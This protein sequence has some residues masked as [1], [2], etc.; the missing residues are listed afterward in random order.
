VFPN[1]L[2]SASSFL[3][4]QSSSLANYPGATSL[5]L[6]YVNSPNTVFDVANQN[7]NGLLVVGGLRSV[8][9][10][11]TELLNDARLMRKFEVG[12]QS[13]DATLGFYVANVSQ[14]FTRYSSSALL[15]VRDNARLLNLVAVNAAGNVIGTITDDGFYRYGYEWANA[16]G[17]STT[18]AFY[19][20][21]EWQV[22]DRLRIDLGVRREEVHLTANTELRQTVNLGTP[23][24]SAMI[25]GTGQFAHFDEKF[26]KAGW[27]IG[28][29]WQFTERSGLFS[30]Y[31][32]A[33]RLPNLST[34]V[35]SSPTAANPTVNKPIIQ[36]MDLGEVGYK[37]ANRWTN[38][39]ATAFWT[40]YDNVSFTNNVFNLNN[41]TSTTQ[42]LYAN[43]RT[44]GLELEGGF[45]PFDWFDVTLSGT[46]EHPEYD[47][48][49]YTDKVNNAPVLRDFDGNRLIR[50]PKTSLRIV[51]G[52][53]LLDQRL[54]L[55]ASWEYEGGRFV[56]TA[57]SVVLPSYDVLNASARFSVTD[58]MDL[59]GY[60]DNVTNSLG[61]TEGNPRAGEVQS[62]DAG[63]NTFLARP[64]LGRA[65]RVSLMYRF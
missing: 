35:T 19:L 55:Q 53:N 6:R 8:T 57:N 23:D 56:D 11:V 16:N 5:Q 65:Y 22:T 33:F 29:N 30:R 58:N 14:D 43:T 45:Y 31:T 21:D 63:A 7:G 46:L 32:S 61:L 28:G 27:T 2:Q 26:N 39:Y 49:V 4:Q 13:H 64:I 10:P 9:S 51:P 62:V 44:Y 17:Q 24:T 34:Y 40:K 47:G 12:S 50:V 54:R 20:A 42:Q 1:T 52:F 36:T 41:S 59:Y 15:D 25:T 38:L 3:T 60:V 37:Y 48:L 18:T